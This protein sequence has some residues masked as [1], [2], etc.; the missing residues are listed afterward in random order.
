MSDPD[1][2]KGEA[3]WLPRA[4]EQFSTKARSNTPGLLRAYIRE[5][6]EAVM[7]VKQ[8][9]GLSWPQVAVLLSKRGLTKAD[10]SPLDGN[11]VGVTAAQVRWE[12]CPR[13]R[14]RRTW[15]SNGKQITSEAASTPPNPPAPPPPIPTAPP[16][17]SGTGTG[18]AA[19]VPSRDVLEQPW[20]S[21]AR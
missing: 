20:L 15:T 5:H 19:A 17:A 11:M 4:A 16:P 7:A 13:S 10:G 12:R 1:D 14:K 2:K 6:F 9:R 18:D 8:D 3:D 21:P